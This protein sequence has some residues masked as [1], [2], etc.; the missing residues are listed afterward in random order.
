ME[1]MSI[2]TRNKIRLEKDKKIKFLLVKLKGDGTGMSNNQGID[3]KQ[4]F[5]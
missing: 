4:T 1:K 2:S 5:Y 3:E